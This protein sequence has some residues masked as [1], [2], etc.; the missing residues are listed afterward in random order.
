[1][2][3]LAKAVAAS[4]WKFAG[5]LLGALAL[6]PVFTGGAWGLSVKVLL[7]VAALGSAVVIGVRRPV[8]SRGSAMNVMRVTSR[9]GLGARTGVA[10]IEFEGRRLLVA[11]GDGFTQVLDQAGMGRQRRRRRE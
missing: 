5:L 1:M 6:A 3:S 7:G 11:F 4:K 2:N 8:H 10:V 9:S